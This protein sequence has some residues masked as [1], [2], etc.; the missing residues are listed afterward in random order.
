MDIPPGHE[1]N[2]DQIAYWNGPGGQHW[3]DRQQAQDT[4]LAP[5]SDILIDR[6][7]PKA[8]ERIVDVGCGCGATSIAFAQKVGPTGHV[9]GIDISVPMLARARQ[10][11]PAG[12]PVDFVLADATVYPFDTASFDLLVSRFG[13]M[14]FAEPAISFANMRRALRPS[15]R[16]TFACWREPRH[17]P[18]MMTALQAVYRHVPELP[19]PGP[20][21]PGPFSFASEQRV[22]R[23]LNEAGFSGVKMERCDLSL[24]VAIGRGLDAAVE[25][26]LEIGP[27]SRAL[28]G[29]PAE[30]RAAAGNSIRE[31]LT[32]FARGQ[33]VPLPASIWMVTAPAS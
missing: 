17:N 9:F 11:A 33:A 14:F 4:L 23:I 26:G 5:I 22:Q 31:A 7:K 13:V 2:A 12:L 27:A 8:G 6:A 10:L 19:Q 28:E 3:T 16:L 32:P 21:D 25:T 1:L 24:D 18:W 29:Q 20:E 30:V 15:G